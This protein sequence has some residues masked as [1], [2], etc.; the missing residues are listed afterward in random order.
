MIRMRTCRSLRLRLFGFVFAT[1]A[2]FPAAQ[3]QTAMPNQPVAT[4]PLVTEVC[5]ACHGVDGN[6]T[7]G[8]FPSLAGQVDAYLEG[9]L[10]AFA[11][12]GNQ[13]V[14]GVMGAMAV[15]LSTDEMKR[16]A[17]WFA[18]QTPRPAP[19]AAVHPATVARGERIYFEGLPDRGVDSC[20]SCHGVRAQGLPDLFPRL[21][22]QHMRYLAEQ[23]RYFR[24]GRRTSDPGAMMRKIATNL[25]DNDIDAVSQYLAVL[26]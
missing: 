22:S 16:A 26:H 20:A 11:A 18:R 13:R 10:H 1:L 3:A 17:T 12:Q 8:R 7:S 21:A 25:S 15:N 4:R 14:S 2:G 19:L 24:A 6:S 9:Q 5:A 23:L